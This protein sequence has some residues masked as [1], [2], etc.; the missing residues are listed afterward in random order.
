[1]QRVA[2]CFLR[3]DEDGSIHRHVHR[4]R[5]HLDAPFLEVLA[6]TVQD[7]GESNDFSNDSSKE[8]K[9]FHFLIYS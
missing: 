5:F 8:I 2:R 9:K 4:E 7:P 1:M 6:S 3:V